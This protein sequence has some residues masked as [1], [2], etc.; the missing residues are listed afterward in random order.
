[1][2]DM[3]SMVMGYDQ[4]IDLPDITTMGGKPRLGL[5]TVYP[6]IEEQFHAARL[7]VDAVAVAA[8]LERYRQNIHSIYIRETGR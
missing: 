3:V 8:R 7:N 5:F 4:A 6:G 1:M 2:P